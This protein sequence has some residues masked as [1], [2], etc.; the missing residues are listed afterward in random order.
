[1]VSVL[2][3]NAPVLGTVLADLFS[4]DFLTAAFCCHQNHPEAQ[5]KTVYLSSLQNLAVLW[6]KHTHPHSL[7]SLLPP[8]I[9]Q[10]PMF[11]PDITA[12]VPPPKKNGPSHSIRPSQEVW[13]W[14]A[15]PAA[16]R[17]RRDWNSGRW[18]HRTIASTNC[19]TVS[20]MVGSSSWLVI[21]ARCFCWFCKKTLSWRV[22]GGSWLGN[23]EN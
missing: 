13:T 5:Q 17:R 12:K 9:S 16:A 11:L 6:N 19:W 10:D 22:F 2:S 14:P 1:M 7:P 15:P 4:E 18:A 21:F 20:R 23:I 8:K 3:L